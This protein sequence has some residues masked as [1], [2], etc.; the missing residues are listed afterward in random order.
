MHICFVDDLLMCYRAD[1]TSIQLILQAFNHF[2]S[3]S[4]L[5]EN[6]DKHSLYIT[7]VSQELKDQIFAE[8]YFA[9]GEMPFKYLGVPSRKITI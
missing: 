9:L 7:S 2:S 3:F 1:R 5:K 6:L 8:M 4:G